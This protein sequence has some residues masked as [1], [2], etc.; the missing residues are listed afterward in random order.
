M[1]TE[2]MER[3]NALLHV[4]DPESPALEPTRLQ[5]LLAD[6][7]FSLFVAVDETGEI[8]GML[9]LTC[10]QTLSRDKYWIEDVIV[11]DCHRG[12][13]IGR[14]LVRAAL[15]Y[16]RAQERLPS[17]YL[18]SNPSRTAARSLYVSEG[19]EEYETGVFRITGF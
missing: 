19:F 4:L 14:A 13:G 2:Q 18:T 5:S 1:T 17:V 16:A 12:L 6:D 7:A 11:D 8:A 3:I 9:T 10:C 15:E